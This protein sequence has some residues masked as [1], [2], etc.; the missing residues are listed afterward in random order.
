MS[1]ALASF[2]LFDHLREGAARI[3]TMRRLA[4]GVAASLALVG[5]WLVLHMPERYEASAR[6]YVDTQSVLKPLM[7]GLA[8]QPDIE[9]QV[10]VLARTVLT[11]PNLEGLLRNPELAPLA[12]TSEEREAALSRLMKGIKLAATDSGLYVISYRDSDPRRALAV[13]VATLDLFM[14]A[15]SG[16]KVRDSK[17]ARQFI[18]DQISA[19]EVELAATESRLKEFKLRNFG[20]NGLS[21]QDHFLRISTLSSQFQRLTAELQAAERMRDSYRRELI[22]ET[23][24]PSRDIDHQGVLLPITEF[25]EVL[26]AERNRLGDLQQ[27]FTDR[28]PDVVALNQRI[29]WLEA[30]RRSEL[31]SGSRVRGGKALVMVATSPIYQRLRVALADSEAQVV[32]LRSR[33]DNERRQLEEARSFASRM[34]MVEA[35]LAQLSRDHDAIRKNY[36]QMVARRE[37][38]SLGVK[39]DESARLRDFRVI[40]PPQVGSQ[41]VFP[42]RAA[43]A[44]AAMMLSIGVGLSAPALLH[45]L[46]PTF[47]EAHSLRAWTGRPVLAT[48]SLSLGAT[49]RRRRRQADLAFAA[50]AVSLLAMQGFWLTSVIWPI[51]G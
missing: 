37:S 14:Q 24:Q 19:Y 5:A 18:S 31:E 46:R 42:G 36:E 12:T 1:G 25:D 44:V 20:V 41:P 47:S 3:W 13:T 39:L 38:A 32:S 2:G 30:Q 27:R 6:V 51:G 26:S 40:E 16:D 9:Q 33:V 23:S 8:F 22:G 4:L 17:A 21:N 45:R 43:M 35:E 11:R 50:G 15:G 10:R 7:D 48:V 29:E 49:A 28:H 34:P